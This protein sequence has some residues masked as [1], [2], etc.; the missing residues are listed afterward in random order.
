MD[1]ITLQLSVR[2]QGDDL[3]KSIASTFEELLGLAESLPV[4]ADE[5]TREVHW[6]GTGEIV[7]L[8]RQCGG[9]F[10]LFLSGQEL[11]ATSSLVRRHLKFD[12]W[13]RT[14]GE[15]F[16][17]NRLVF[18]PE[19]HFTA[20]AAFLAE[21]LLRR[22][23]VT[24][25]ELGFART[26]PLIEIALRRISLSEESIL[27]LMGELRFL[28]TLLLIAGPERYAEALASWRGYE[29]GSRDFVF[30]LGGIEVKSTRRDRSVHPISNVM[31]VDPRRDSSGH[32][33]EELY[34]LSL[35]FESVASDD[36]VGNALTLPAQVDQ[37]L[38]LLAPT[39]SKA[40][41]G[42]LQQLFLKQLESY[43]GDTECGYRH[44]EMR[45]WDAYSKG[46]Q[47]H[48]I[49]I[50]DMSD[51]AIQVLRRDDVQRRGNVVLDS[52][53]FTIELPDSITGDLNPQTDLRKLAQHI[54]G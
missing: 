32:P 53:K 36:Q 31:Q 7:G 1:Q 17:A 38:S 21:E 3:N 44:E 27:G 34:L 22:D 51:D 50:Y 29:R 9:S 25:L 13:T 10:E 54:L 33:N 26:E 49:R 43:G 18:P 47:H 28:Q 11:H 40:N 42:E 4:S 6:C 39:D 35:G 12:Q 30:R 23:V 15:V 19:D 14:G 48:F 20:M 16:Q 24:S 2:R 8:S 46:W 5:D 52:V 41:F 37:L 45:N